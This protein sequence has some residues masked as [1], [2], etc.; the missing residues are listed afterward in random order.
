[1][2]PYTDALVNSICRL[3]HDHREPI[4]AISGQPPLPQRLPAGCPFHPRCASAAA[5]C[6]ESEPGLIPLPDDSSAA[7]W[8]AEERVGGGG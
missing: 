2:H 3:D 7:C 8:F 1:V 6:R 5:R 4:A